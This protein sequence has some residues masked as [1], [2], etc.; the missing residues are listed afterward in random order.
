M[1]MEPDFED[2]DPQMC[3]ICGELVHP[4]CMEAELGE[5]CLNCDEKEEG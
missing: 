1:E 3:N 4:G 5:W 2:L